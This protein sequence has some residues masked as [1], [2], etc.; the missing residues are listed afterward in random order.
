MLTDF[1]SDGWFHD[2]FTLCS[3][4][5]DMLAF[6][7]KHNQG[8]KHLNPPVSVQ[9]CKTK[10]GPVFIECE[11]I[12]PRQNKVPRIPCEDVSTAL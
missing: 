11:S 5:P 2:V 8:Y 7:L 4:E 10:R 12:C 3:T 6:E 9:H 1:L